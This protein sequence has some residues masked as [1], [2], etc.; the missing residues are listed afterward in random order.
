MTGDEIKA[1][2]SGKTVYLECGATSTGGTGQGIIYYA[3]DGSALYKSAG[4][5]MLLGTWAVKGNTSCT[6]WKEVPVELTVE[7]V[8]RFRGAGDKPRPQSGLVDRWC[9]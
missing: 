3:A 1:T 4:K 5:G 8:L 2:I 9:G 6:D 7:V